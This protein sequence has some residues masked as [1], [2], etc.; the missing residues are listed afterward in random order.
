MSKEIKVREGLTVEIAPLTIKE[1]MQADKI[2]GVEAGD[3]PTVAALM[4]LN[5]KVYTICAIR[6]ING[7]PVAP[8]AGGA[9][10]DS[11]MSKFSL[12]EL[13]NLS[14]EYSELEGVDAESLKNESSAEG[15]AT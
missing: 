14:K 4:S 8:I 10:F 6:K 3:E 2:V 9:I 11:I 1:S 5:T 12:K 15:S 13:M 7:A